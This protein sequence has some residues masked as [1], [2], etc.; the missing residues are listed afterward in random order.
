MRTRSLIG[1]LP[2]TGGN[3]MTGASVAL[4]MLAEA[5]QDGLTDEEILARSPTAALTAPGR[6]VRRSCP[7]G[8]GGLYTSTG[9]RPVATRGIVREAL[10]LRVRWVQEISGRAAWE[11]GVRLTP[12][13]TSPSPSSSVT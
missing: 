8:G 7:R 10:R 6:T 13:T 3:R 1:M 11:L 12:P 4:Q 9:C 5:R 2:D